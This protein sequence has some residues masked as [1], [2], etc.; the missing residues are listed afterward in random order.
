LQGERKEILTYPRQSETEIMDSNLLSM[1]V[2]AAAAF[3][4]AIIGA[5][6]AIVG[7]IIGGWIQ[8]WAWYHYEQKRATA[9]KRE[10][11]IQITRDWAATGR[12]ES[13]SEA[14]LR[15]AKLGEVDLGPGKERDDG[16]DLSYADM[17]EA[18]LY[19]GI[20]ERARLKYANLQGATLLWANLSEADLWC[21]KLQRAELA[22]VDLRGAQLGSADLR[23]AILWDANLQDADL[24]DANLQ[25]ADLSDAN[26]HGAK[27]RGAKYSKLTTRWP[28]GFDLPPEAINMDA[29]TGVKD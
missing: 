21:A 14:D 15:G 25:G 23:G 19:R 6:V 5:I 3:V 11:W 20:L 24:S 26:L 8:G 12:K 17:R 1:L 28:E 29:E 9:E 18:N 13:L 27:L 10:R 4:G 7:G 2:S 22:Y 16:A